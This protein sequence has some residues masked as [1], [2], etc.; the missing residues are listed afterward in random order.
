MD[1]SSPAVANP[2]F[3]NAP[4]SQAAAGQREVAAGERFNQ[5]APAPLLSQHAICKLGIDRRFSE[6]RLL[7]SGGHCDVYG[8]YDA[9][10]EQELALK[11][12]GSQR[13]NRQ[14]DR[15]RF[16]LEPAVLGHLN[17]KTIPN[18]YEV[19]PERMVKPYFTMEWISGVDLCRVLRGLQQG[20]AATMADYPLRRLLEMVCNVA[21]GL[22]VAHAAGIIHRDVKPENLMLTSG[23]GVKIVDWGVVL[24]LPTSGGYLESLDSEAQEKSQPQRERRRHHYRLTEVG[25]QVGTP[26]YMAPEQI[27]NH[28]AIDQRADIFSLGAV[29]YDCL[30]LTTLIRGQTRGDAFRYTM[31]G[32]YL[33]PSQ[34]TL[35]ASV[36]AGVEGV[37]LRAVAPDRR[38]R[39]ADMNEF[40]QALRAELA[41]L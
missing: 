23:G 35:R 7:G 9:L 17:H 24:C 31:A 28:L 25:Q 34:V 20:N 4:V 5:G 1:T 39:F 15:A 16:L 18:V 13:T 21:D 40:A 36:P 41:R 22:S 10:R 29:L 19:F 37:C 3:A 6:L 11:R 33:P 27:D 8:C 12:L 2:A 30:A 38:D 14:A 26:L 32:D